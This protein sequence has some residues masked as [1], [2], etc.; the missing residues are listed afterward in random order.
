MGNRIFTTGPITNAQIKAIYEHAAKLGVSIAPWQDHLGPNR[1][2]FKW[3][4]EG[5]WI[6]GAKMIKYLKTFK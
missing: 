5:G 3:S 2:W 4:V 1:S 6:R